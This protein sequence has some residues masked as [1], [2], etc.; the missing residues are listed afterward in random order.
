MPALPSSLISSLSCAPAL[1]VPEAAG[2]LSAA[3]AGLPDPRAR[4]GVW[5]RLTVVVTAAVCAVVAGYRSYAAIP[6]WVADVPAA[7][8]LALDMTPERRPSEAMIRRLLQAM[9]PQHQEVYA[10]LT[11]YQALRLDM[12]GATDHDPDNDPDRASF[13]IVLNTARDQVIHAVGVIAGTVIDLIGKIG[14]AVLND[15]L[16]GRRTRISPRVV[17]RAIFKHRA[18]GNIDRTNHQTTITITLGLTTSPDP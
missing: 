15:L 13:T 1:A 2:G 3:L 16:P 4:R 11:A 12:T 9:D 6:E 5:H 7:T 8:A 17:K 10:L 18:K 14:R